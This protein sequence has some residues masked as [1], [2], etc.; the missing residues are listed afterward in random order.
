MKYIFGPITFRYKNIIYAYILYSFSF[1]FVMH[2]ISPCTSVPRLP[3]W[4][5][6][7]RIFF[8]FLFS[9]T[10]SQAGSLDWSAILKT[11]RS[12]HFREFGLK[13]C[14]KRAFG[15]FLLLSYFFR[16]TFCSLPT[17]FPFCV[18]FRLF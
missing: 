8:F 15:F 16:G 6:R 18:F 12:L 13:A 2:Q 1:F 9:E 7:S 5:Q 14:S 17:E 3:V 11:C 4:L 10:G